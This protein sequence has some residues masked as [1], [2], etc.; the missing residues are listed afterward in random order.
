LT[1]QPYPRNI[2]GTLT[3][4]SNAV[5]TVT[6][7]VTPIL[8]GCANGAPVITTVQV[9][10]TPIVSAVN[11]I[12]TI[13]NGGSPNI[14]VTSLTVPTNPGNLTFDVIVS[15]SDAPSTGGSAF[16]NQLGLSAPFDIN[17]VDGILTNS[18]NADLTV[19][20]TIVPKL[21][22]CPD[23]TPIAVNVVVEPSPVAV[24][25]NSTPT[26]CNSGNVNIL[27]SSP[28]VPTVPADLRFDLAVTSSNAGATGGT[29]FTPL[30]NQSFPVLI[31]GTLTNSSNSFITVTYT[32]TPKLGLC[33][34]GTP[35]V[36]NVIVEPTPQVDFV[37]NAPRLCDGGTPDFDITS[38]STVSI[39]G[40]LTFDITPSL[41]PGIIGTGDAG[42]GVTSVGVPF[43][44]NNGTL[45]NTTNISQNVTYTIT[46]KLGGCIN[47]PTKI[48][49]VIVEPTP[50]VSLTNNLAKI[51]NLGTPNI[52]V[53]SPTAPS[54]PADLTFDVVVTLPGGVSGT[55]IAGNGVIGATA[56]FSVNTGVI[57][58][59][60]PTSQTITYTVTPK[61]NG[62]ADGPS[63]FV[64]VIVEPTP[65][66]VVNNLLPTICN[67][68]TP[69]IDVT[70]PTVPSVPANQTFDVAVSLPA[71]VS[72]T[73][74]A[75]G[76]ITGATAPFSINAGTLTNSTNSFRTVTYTIT[77][78]LTGCANGTPQVV[79][80]I[81]EPSPVA[82]VVNNAAAICSGASP[83]IDV[84]SPTSPSIPGNLTFDVSV[85]LQAGLTGTGVAGSGVLG[86]TA[87][88]S[89][90]TGI[91]THD[92]LSNVPLTATY[93]ITPRLAGCVDGTPQVVV[94]T[95]RP[96]PVGAFDNSRI[97][98]SDEPFTYNIQTANIDLLGNQVSSNFIFTVSSSDEGNVPTP[99]ALDRPVASGAPINGNFNNLSGADVDI[100][101]TITPFNVLG[102]CAGAPF[103]VVVRVRTEPTAPAITTVEHCSEDAAPFVFD[104]QTIIDT[105][106][107]GNGVPSNFTYTVSS[108]NPLAVFPESNRNV[109]SAV[110]ISHVY[111]N[112]TSNDET[113]TYVVTPFSIA[114]NCQGTNFEFR[115]IV[116]PEPVGSNLVDP[117]CSTLLNHNI[118]T[119]ITN[120]LNSIFIYT[121]VSDNPGVPAGPDRLVASNA[122]ITDNYVNGT[123][124]PANIT[125]TITPFNAA[126]PTCAGSPFTYRVNVSPN[127]TGI[128][129]VKPVVC[130][131]VPFN[132]DPQANI[133]PPVASTFTWTATYDAPMTGPAAGVGV[134]SG[135]LN[136]TTGGQ[137]FAHYTVVPTA[138][139]CVGAPFTIDLPVDPEPVMLPALSA[140]PAVCST[141]PV[142]PNPINVILDTNGLSVAAASYDITLKSQDAG[143]VGIATTG[144]FPANSPAAGLSDAISLDTYTNTTAA[145]LQVV[146]TV[147][148]ISATG[149]QGN[150]FDV[151]VSVNPEPVL[152]NPGFPD[153]CSS[154]ADSN[155]PVNIVLGTNG[156]SVN[157]ASYRL[158]GI[159]FSDGGPFAAPLPPGFTANPANAAI[160]TLGSINLIR[161]DRFNNTSTVQVTVRYS[162]QGFSTQGCASELLDYDVVVNPEPVLDP[163]LTPA[164][165]CSGVVSGITLG[166][167]PGSVA[168]ATYN[169]NNIILQPGLVAGGTNAPIGA[170]QLAN[171]VFNDVFTNTTSSPLT[172]TYR[173]VPVTAAGCPGAEQ[174]VI[175]TVNPSPAIANNL[176][177]TVCDNEAANILLA[178][179][180]LSAPVVSY[181]IINVAVPAGLTQ[182]V[183]SS[184]PRNG[185]LANEIQ[186]D[187]FQNT[188]N[189]PII[190]T[191]TVEGVT[192]A[193]CIG[194][195]KDILLTVE[196][197][198][199]VV[200][201]NNSLS[202]CSATATNI[203]LN[204]PTTATA[205]VITFNYIAVS[206]IGGQ[207]TGF[208]PALN[209]LPQGFTI[210]DV[211]VNNSDNPAMV[212]Y[213]ITPVANG[214]KGGAGCVGVPVVEVV[215]V[216]PKPKLIASPLIQ[217]VCETD[218]LNVS[219]TNITLTSGTNP[220]AGTLEFTVVNTATT[221]GLTLL[222]PVKTVYL[223]GESITDQ[224]D[225]PT[226]TDQT[227]TYTVRPSI[228]GG[229]GCSGD[230]VVVTIT[231]KP[232]PVISPVA[233]VTICSGEF[234]SIPFVMDIP[235][236]FATWTVSAPPSINGALNGGGISLNA[237]LFNSGFNTETVT[238]TVTP[239]FN[240]CDGIPITIDVIVNPTPNLNG[241]PLSVTVCDGE[242]LNI[243]LTSNVAG[244]TFDW[245]VTD[246][247]NLEAPGFFDG[248]GTTINQVVNNP[249]GF[250]AI[251]I[252]QV[253][254]RTAAGCVGLPRIMNVN[255][256][257]IVTNVTPDK[258]AIC[259]GDRV[260]VTNS[261]LGATSHRWFYREQGTTQEV[262][263]RTT[264]FVNYQLD[265]NTTINPL[266]LEIVYQPSNGLCSVP[267]VVIPI[268]VYRNITAGFD[269][270]T[271]PP[272]VGGSSTVNFSN[273][274]N[275][276]DP[277]QFRYEWNF[278]TDSSPATF[279]GATPPPVVYSLQGPHQVT[280]TVTN[281]AAEAAG[282]TC[283][284]T[285]NKTIIVPILP[286]VADFTLDPVAACFPSNVRVIENISTGDVMEWR[287]VNSNGQTV[288]V[289][290]V[291]LPEFFITAP[292]VFNVQLIT[293]DSFTGQVAF[294]NKDFII[295]DNPLASF[296]ARPSVVFVPDTELA[297]FNFSER[298]NFFAWDF[299]DGETSDEREPKHVYKLEG[300]FDITLIAGFEHDDGVVCTD[301]TVQKVTARQ[302][303]I[304][305]IPNAF[306]PN[307]A[308]GS[309]GGVAGSGTFNDVFL[310]LVKGVEEF[311]MQIFDRWGNLIF[312]SNNSNVGW[313]GFDRNGNILPAGVYVF[314]LT[315]R[316]SDGQRTT[317]VGDITM[318]R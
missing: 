176:N 213:T 83:S 302:G 49:N 212:T 120:G 80:V 74:V 183:G 175:F 72:G 64:D 77:P 112:F 258:T 228:N 48:V 113:I 154:N 13:C 47:G 19:T 198:I 109:P 246:V 138:G 301:T 5:I 209:N 297:T 244:T 184:L 41:P 310:P 59:T 180:P 26:I 192:G 60:N 70:S 273:T 56:P 234:T 311:N 289:S 132:I 292:G 12:G 11:N 84:T 214:A 288:G 87:P 306:T 223:N 126:N 9:E 303:G 162:I 291:D 117:V 115:V 215:T 239:K 105:G 51:C 318:I 243:P 99:I 275:P 224:W 28:T 241:L 111:A 305:K 20:Y 237:T 206:S 124:I 188:T 272:I 89:I 259:S 287:V 194:P 240:N 92:N 65:V 226:L 189:A 268:T 107:G 88:F 313:D 103:D 46:P 1:G 316:L 40:N 39:P 279:T 174:N 190:V 294:A 282:L 167:A 284:S 205:G 141:N 238:Y 150:P 134:I 119:Q 255:V 34:N 201:V 38:P 250:Q 142:S 283:T 196:P 151:T 171:A 211:L 200:P 156:V 121:V 30:V 170:G 25:G 54:V 123:G 42:T 94:V 100:T 280:L 127:P 208:V 10:P 207:M 252:Y 27:I 24:I 309:S 281:I 203:V 161:N 220:S 157:A 95:V 245:V 217:T 260:Q 8:A 271:V 129:D 274:S 4:S 178:T 165:V 139:T 45:T 222:S 221:G 277:G 181:N 254:P 90:N 158:Q 6:Y 68:G 216:E 91:L 315:L 210:A 66:A 32:V 202:I 155:N 137:L 86:A 285:F 269:E 317:Q 50:Q 191:Y 71:G 43:S 57:T 140:P 44:F 236:T 82:T 266:I 278:G 169:I 264:P 81:V 63:Q 231:V 247:F 308:G 125:Y 168:A 251:L 18:S 173:V 304:T 235:G 253:T 312:E 55:G 164:P 146:Y 233:P 149:C 58:N 73:G 3:N 23:G 293:K 261:T 104:L 177:R 69:N 116:H 98:C 75:G 166:V 296:Q 307:L 204:S 76:G 17:A 106:V 182:T 257:S 108:S 53:T 36:T 145:Q 187:Q 227:V 67:G 96:L 262:D 37:N 265:N 295:H 2:N 270:G 148:P 22:G 199:E 153:V 193:G 219:P 290:F 267:D 29:A 225:N 232:R 78:R 163:A 172:V 21:A 179:D 79:N 186:L 249:F 143:L 152:D 85:V 33:P 300:V 256:G 31:G 136:N 135:S 159:L 299:G 97:V 102:N 61:L 62:C 195:Q 197:P 35:Q 52:T 229:L 218:A 118:Q 114:G 185:V 130:S 242:T 14:N 7:T 122:P 15:S 110:P 128:S 147:V 133:V 16:V 263:V 314:K 248:G 230:D 298:A 144:L 93:T 101:Y 131:D 286:L 160:G 276:V